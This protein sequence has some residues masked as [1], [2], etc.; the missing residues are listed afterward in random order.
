MGNIFSNQDSERQF[1]DVE[2]QQQEKKKQQQFEQQRLWEQI[3]EQRKQLK[4]QRQQEREKQQQQQQRLELVYNLQDDQA[5]EKYNLV[6]T[7]NDQDNQD[8][9]ADNQD[10]QADNQDY[11]A[12]Y[13][14]YQ[15]NNH[16]NYSE[17]VDLGRWRQERKMN[18]AR[19]SSATCGRRKRGR[20]GRGDLYDEDYHAG[21]SKKAIKEKCLERQ[22]AY[23]ARYLRATASK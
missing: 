13:Q 2:R 4:I 7:L 17:D 3:W 18:A 8:C 20:K 14:D 16:W 21:H 1:L 15:A 23:Q 22:A 6:W 12:D 10:Y 19:Q 11:Q 5:N 9:Q